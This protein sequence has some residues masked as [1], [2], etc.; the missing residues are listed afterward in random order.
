MCFRKKPRPIVDEG[1]DNSG[2]VELYDYQAAGVKLQNAGA[3]LFSRSGAQAILPDGTKTP[4]FKNSSNE[5]E[6]QQLLAYLEK[7]HSNILE[8]SGSTDLK[9]DKTSVTKDEETGDVT[10]ATET[11]GGLTGSVTFEAADTET[12]EGLNEAIEGLQAEIEGLKGE[13]AAATEAAV[14]A[15]LAAQAEEAAKLQA[16]LDAAKARSETDA[17]ALAEAEAAAAKLADETQRAEE[18]GAVVDTTVDSAVNQAYVDAAI[19]A[20]LKDITTESA[21]TQFSDVD[22]L[23]EGDA[24]LLDSD[25]KTLDPVKPVGITSVVYKTIVQR[26][27]SEAAKLQEQVAREELRRARVDRAIQKRSLMRRRIESSAQ[28]G[29]GRIV[30][31][32]TETELDVGQPSAPITKATG[33]RGGRG[34]GSLISGSRGGIGFYSRFS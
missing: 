16:D 10:V 6:K 25:I 32:G 30:R 3:S 24:T 23:T 34:R 28:V 2:A 11:A 5:V 26:E 20:A 22:V 18:S 33:M 9:E 15:A 7:N 1:I 14:A 17:A 8:G 31:S 29:A 13:N 4:I 12:V 21:A 19:E 27:P